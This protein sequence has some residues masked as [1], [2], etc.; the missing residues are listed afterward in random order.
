VNSAIVRAAAKGIVLS[1]DRSLLF[2][3]GG[4]IELT[5]SWAKSLL[6]RM[7]MVK[8]KG[9]TSKKTFVVENFTQE[10]DK[11]LKSIKSKVEMYKITPELVINWDETGINIVPVSQ[12]TKDVEGAKRVEITG[13][14]DK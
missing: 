5:K 6:I 7:N 2:E 4:H 9:T 3:N 10:K 1:H 12:W 11:Y 8:R 14:D 13:I